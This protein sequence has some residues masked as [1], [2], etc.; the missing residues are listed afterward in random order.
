MTGKEKQER[1][2]GWLDSDYYYPARLGV[3]KK[4]IGSLFDSMQI[5]MTRKR[6]VNQF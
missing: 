5:K 4:A 2:K 1:D 6:K 3:V